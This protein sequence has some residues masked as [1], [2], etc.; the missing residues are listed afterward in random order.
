MSAGSFL[1]VEDKRRGGLITSTFLFSPDSK[2]VVYPASLT[3]TFQPGLV[4]DGKFVP[5]PTNNGIDPIN[6]FFTPDSRHFIVT[7]R[8]PVQGQPSAQQLTVFVDGRPSARFEGAAG[9]LLTNPWAWEMGQDGTLTALFLDGNDL[10]R[11][12]I[13]PANDTSVDTMVAAAQAIK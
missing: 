3:T 1:K 4:I 6:P 13:T 9:N 5:I 2:H 8:T 11:V 7:A 12:R 10:K